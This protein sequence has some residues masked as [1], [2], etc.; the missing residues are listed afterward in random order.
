MLRA[1]H[2]LAEPPDSA[3]TGTKKELIYARRTAHTEFK[4]KMHA[5]NWKKVR[6]N[7]SFKDIVAKGSKQVRL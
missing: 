3:T 7:N 2:P 5:G 1:D 4:G 6:I